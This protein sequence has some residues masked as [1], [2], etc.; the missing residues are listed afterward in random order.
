MAAFAT[1]QDYAGAFGDMDVGTR[2]WENLHSEIPSMADLTVEK[3]AI[4][5]TT[6][7]SFP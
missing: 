1:T 4:I 6:W 2:S 3:L 7:V 5:A